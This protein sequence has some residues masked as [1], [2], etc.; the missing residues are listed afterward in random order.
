MDFKAVR[1]SLRGPGALVSSI[2]NSDLSLNPKAI[3]NNVRAMMDRGFGQND[4]FF[5]APCGDGEYVSLNPEENGQVVAA[6]RAALLGRP[7]SPR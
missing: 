7:A 2:F 4:G 5:I 6:V 1:E 3:E